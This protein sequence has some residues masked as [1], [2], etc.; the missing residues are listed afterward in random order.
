MAS[1]TALCPQGQVSGLGGQGKLHLSFCQVQ[2][3]L[4]P[5]VF[6]AVIMLAL[7]KT[8]LIAA[9]VFVNIEAFAIIRV[10]QTLPW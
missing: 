5:L 2:K 9:E 4:Q 3:V 1:R 6:Q 10:S 7:N 8:V